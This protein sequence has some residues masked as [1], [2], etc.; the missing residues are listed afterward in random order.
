VKVI[1]YNIPAGFLPRMFFLSLIYVLQWKKYYIRK[2]ICSI[3]DFGFT[4]FIGNN[5]FFRSF[6]L[7]V[8]NMS[9]LV[10][11]NRTVILLSIEDIRNSAILYPFYRL[12]HGRFV[13]LQSFQRLVNDFYP[14]C[15]C[16]LVVFNFWS[17][18][19]RCGIQPKAISFSLEYMLAV[20]SR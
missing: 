20:R 8:V 2:T 3:A 17:G 12:F 13:A 5:P 18:R 4:F 9:V 19:V 6:F 16:L 11:W 14:V 1:R 7:F 10:K 15:K